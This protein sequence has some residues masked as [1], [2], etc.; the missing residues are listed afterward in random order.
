[1]I[2]SSIVLAL[3]QLGDL[4]FLRVLVLGVL[5]SAGLLVGLYFGLSGFLDWLLPDSLTL[6]WIGTINWLEAAA[7]WGTLALMLVASIFL[8][9]PVAAL[10]AGLFTESIADAVEDRHYPTLAPAQPE[11]LAAALWG[12]VRFFL[13]ILVANLLALFFYL[14]AGPFGPAV[15]WLVNGYLLGREYFETVAIRR[16]GRQRARA[17]RK[18]NALTVWLMGALMAAP[19]TVPLLSLFVPVVGVATFTHLFHRLNGLTPRR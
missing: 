17:M 9:V 18:S 19:L 4:R 1:M 10:F 8:M 7:N 2:L 15:F 13:V 11:P 12:T 3:S 6:P 16:I 14:I 5:L